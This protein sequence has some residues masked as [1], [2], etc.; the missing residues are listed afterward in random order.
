VS[1]ARPKPEPIEWRP[2]P[3]LAPSPVRVGPISSPTA[4]R[5]GQTQPSF[6]DDQ[7]QLFF[8]DE[9]R[10]DNIRGRMPA[11][12]STHQDTPWRNV[13]QP[14]TKPRLSRSPAPGRVTS[15]LPRERSPMNRELLKSYDPLNF[16]LDSRRCVP[17]STLPPQNQF[18]DYPP[19]GHDS[20]F[21]PKTETDGLHP[22]PIN[23]SL[24]APTTTIHKPI[25]ESTGVGPD[26]P[27][28]AM[29]DILME[30]TGVGTGVGTDGLNNTIH[31]IMMAGSG[32]PNNTMHKPMMESI[33]VGPDGPSNT[34]PNIMMESMGVGTGVE[35]DGLNNTIHNAMMESTG[36]GTGVGPD[37]PNNTIQEIMMES[38]EVG[39]GVGTSTQTMFPVEVETQTFLSSHL[40]APWSFA[41]ETQTMWPEARETQTVWPED[42]V[43]ETQTMPNNLEEA[44]DAQRHYVQGQDMHG[45]GAPGIDLSFITKETQTLSQSP[46]VQ[47]GMSP[48]N[49]QQAQFPREPSPKS[50][51]SPAHGNGESTEFFSNEPLVFELHASGPCTPERPAN[52]PLA[53]H[54]NGW[55]RIAEP[56][57]TTIRNAPTAHQSFDL[58]SY[59]PIT[60]WINS[61]A[62]SLPP[63][64]PATEIPPKEKKTCLPVE[65]GP[66]KSILGDQPHNYGTGQLTSC[67][68][69]TDWITN[70][71]RPFPPAIPKNYVIEEPARAQTPP[72]PQTPPPLQ[73][74]QMPPRFPTPPRLPT[75]RQV[76]QTR[77]QNQLTNGNHVQP[78]FAPSQSGEECV[79][80]SSTGQPPIMG[81]VGASYSPPPRAPNR[82]PSKTRR[83]FAR[84][85]SPFGYRGDSALV[86]VPPPAHARVQVPSQSRV[87]HERD[88]YEQTVASKS[89]RGLSVG[90]RFGTQGGPAG[91]DLYAYRPPQCANLAKV[92][93]YNEHGVELFQLPP[94]WIVLRPEGCPLVW[95]VLRQGNSLPFDISCGMLVV[96]WGALTQDPSLHNSEDG[97]LR[98]AIIGDAPAMTPL[99]LDEGLLMSHDRSGP[100]THVRLLLEPNCGRVICHWLKNAK[101]RGIAI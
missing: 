42:L 72:R 91:A 55:P 21:K 40:D 50:A 75:P 26:G 68:P 81:S 77:N 52:V 38:A 17:A 23:T 43:K 58:L 83:G 4:K 2:S 70:T 89:A 53:S 14:V 32:G 41:K 66:S 15:R 67:T 29:P 92:I 60:D 59:T 12:N 22:P 93:T 34:I 33:G 87:A 79:H 98:C 84:S 9:L 96:D 47:P 45:H 78:L 88:A 51:L 20:G 24:D 95:I 13:N 28:V 61:T 99:G 6:P 65:P 27:S 30:S 18:A 101:Q 19:F 35:T 94:R 76:P 37:G 49:T 73:T 64:I 10:S 46:R 63:W 44:A 31:D 85:P 5:Y 71:E 3:V 54:S 69:I 62:P 48:Q 25:M 16:G 57:V 80:M 97:K 90:V 1:G 8:P 86:L 100:N 74:P 7:S 56:P 39:T 82:A 11:M 36:V